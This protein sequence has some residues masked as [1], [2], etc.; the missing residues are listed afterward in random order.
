[1]YM[2]FSAQFE[3]AAGRWEYVGGDGRSPWIYAGSARF[4]Y[5]EAGFTFT[6]DPAQ[7]GDH[8]VFRGVTDFQWRVRKRVH[9]KIRT[10]VID[11]DRLITTAGH[12]SSQADPPGYSAPRCVIDGPAG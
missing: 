10:V 6:F 5:E 9:G 1:M 8:F 2:R 3:D 11:H 7:A 4:S 12:P